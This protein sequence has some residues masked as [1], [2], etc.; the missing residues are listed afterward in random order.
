[1]TLIPAVTNTHN[2][3]ET[4][5][6][7]HAFEIGCTKRKHGTLNPDVIPCISPLNF[8]YPKDQSF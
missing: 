5:M 3:N 6:S 1:M 8:F 4:L 7:L 2:Y